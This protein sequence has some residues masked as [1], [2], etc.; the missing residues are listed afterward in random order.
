M[1]N[2]LNSFNCITYFFRFRDK[3]ESVLENLIHENKLLDDS[4]RYTSSQL[5]ALC[6]YE[7]EKKFHFTGD[8]VWDTNNQQ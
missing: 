7:I 2:F 3:V 6:A 5:L 1:F 4:N 8:G